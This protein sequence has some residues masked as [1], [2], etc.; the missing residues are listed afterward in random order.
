M[1]RA[2]PAPHASTCLPGV[3]FVRR[4]HRIVGIT[5]LVLALTVGAGAAL[6]VW[7][8]VYPIAANEP[9]FAV[10]RWLLTLAKRRSVVEH[11]EA[12]TPPPLRDASLI[13]EGFPLY[14]EHCLVC[15]GA[16]G[17]PRAAMG[18][19]MNPN[20]PPLFMAASRWNDAELFWV[21]RN[22]LKMAGMPGFYPMLEER[23][24]WALSAFTRRLPELS[25]EEYRTMR[26]ELAGR[27]PAG[28]AE[29]ADRDDPGFLAMRQHG[30]A[31]RGKELLD[32]HGCGSC[33]GIPGI[34]NADG[35]AGAPLDRWAE[36]HYIAGAVLNTPNNLVAWIMDPQAIEPGTAMPAVG[37]TAE[38]AWHMAAYLFS[39]GDPPG[40][41]ERR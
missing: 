40:V 24:I 35:R 41:V 25:V 23:E 5:L 27:L 14:Q 33:H 13:R 3:P 32:S 12:I 30:R 26:A 7:S 8:G 34:R 20:P 38:E 4:T 9:H 6:F 19:G 2:P 16:P 28:S 31:D 11:A 29:W 15:H 36:R 18:R 39:L 1:T 21:I 37:A 10:E 22:G 17:E